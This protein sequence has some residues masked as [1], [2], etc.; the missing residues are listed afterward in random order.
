MY[1]IYKKTN[2]CHGSTK[3]IKSFYNKYK[4]RKL[5]IFAIFCGMKLSITTIYYSEKGNHNA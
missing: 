2:L 5:N 4:F 3:L 1:N